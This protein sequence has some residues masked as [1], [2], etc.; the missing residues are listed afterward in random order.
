MED[1]DR[2]DWDE[3]IQSKF[4][5]KRRLNNKR[6]KGKSRVF[7]HQERS[8]KLHRSR[9]RKRINVRQ[10]DPDDFSEDFYDDEE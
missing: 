5:R 7:D 4:T 6:R 10:F 1:K 2:E 3:H 9:V 8:L